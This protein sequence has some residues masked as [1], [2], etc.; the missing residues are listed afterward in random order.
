MR[1]KHR[2][3]D[4]YFAELA[5]R[6]Q[7]TAHCRRTRVRGI[8]QHLRT[9]TSDATDIETPAEHYPGWNR[10]N[11]HAPHSAVTSE[12]PIERQARFS[13]PRAASR[14]GTTIELLFPHLVT[15]AGFR[16]RIKAGSG[17][18]F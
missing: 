6:A 16:A 9:A 7:C 18:Y 4:T 2:D 17:P 11:G 12:R 10:R 1:A 8:A 14:Q 3:A 15:G 5:Y 13:K